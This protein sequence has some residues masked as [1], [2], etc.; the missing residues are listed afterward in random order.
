MQL[1]IN[2]QIKDKSLDI[3]KTPDNQGIAKESK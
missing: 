2:V 3:D 1:Q